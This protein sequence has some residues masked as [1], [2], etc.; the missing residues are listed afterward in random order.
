MACGLFIRLNENEAPRGCRVID[1]Y[2]RQAAAPASHVSV[3]GIHIAVELTLRIGLRLA[4][5]T[6][7]YVTIDRH[8]N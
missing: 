1:S 3:R 5:F 8:R 2:I 6:D 7:L 4:Y